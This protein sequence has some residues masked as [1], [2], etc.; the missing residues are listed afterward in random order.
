MHPCRGSR[1][2]SIKNAA[3]SGQAACNLSNELLQCIAARFGHTGR[4]PHNAIHSDVR[5]L[6]A[7]AKALAVGPHHLL[8]LH[9]C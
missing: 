7:G 6:C 2:G 1:G 5:E 9:D 3:I 8:Y 4:S